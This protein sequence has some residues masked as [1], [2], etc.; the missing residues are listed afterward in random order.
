MVSY[1]RLI[2][3]KDKH[4]QHWWNP[5]NQND[6]IL[7]PRS[8]GFQHEQ[9]RLSVIA[10]IH[11]HHHSS[12]SSSCYHSKQGSS[13]V[14]KVIQ[15]ICQVSVPPLGEAF[16]GGTQNSEIANQFCLLCG[17]RARKNKTNCELF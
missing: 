6:S 11:G 16:F 17:S 2:W 10:T 14:S 12:S 13:T 9:Q 8:M 7:I 15:T 5:F 1:S 3:L 4:Q